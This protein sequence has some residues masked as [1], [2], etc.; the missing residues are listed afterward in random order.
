MPDREKERMEIQKFEYLKNQKRFLDE[1]KSIFH[2][3]LR[4]AI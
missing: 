4:A 2:I 3:Y 1:M